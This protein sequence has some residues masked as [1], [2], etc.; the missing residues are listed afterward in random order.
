VA[1]TK[2]APGLG[3]HYIMVIWGNCTKS[4]NIRNDINNN[5]VSNLKDAED[6]YNE[7]DDD[8]I[9]IAILLVVVMTVITLGIICM[10]HSK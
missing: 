2:L 6:V 5:N 10:F 3:F 4:S 9:I 1:V 7:N 8:N